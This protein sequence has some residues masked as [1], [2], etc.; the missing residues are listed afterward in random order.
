MNT[1]ESR[2]R[3]SSRREKKF[4]INRKNS[5]TVKKSMLFFFF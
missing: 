1:K 3:E 2:V 5:N 4:S